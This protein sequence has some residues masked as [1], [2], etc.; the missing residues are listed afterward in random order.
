MIKLH[1]TDYGPGTFLKNVSQRYLANMFVVELFLNQ[2]AGIN[3]RPGTLDLLKRNLHQAGF[4]VNTLEFT[5]LLQK[6][7]G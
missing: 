6:R 3:S 2:I 4:L 5:A 7:L 1:P